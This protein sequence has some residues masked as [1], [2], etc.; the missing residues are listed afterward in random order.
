MQSQKWH[1]DLHSFPR[2]TIQYH[3]N[4][5]LCPDLECWRSW[6]WMLLWRPTRRSRTNTQKRYP[7]HYR[8]LECKS[9]NSRNTWSNRQI[10]PWS[11][12]WG[13]AKTKSFSKRKQWSEQTFSSNNTREDSTHEHQP[14]GQYQNQIDYILC[15]QRWRS[16]IQSTKTRLGA[17]FGSDYELLIPKFRFK[18]KKVGKTTQVWPKSDPLWLYSKGKDSTGKDRLIQGIRS[19]R[20]PEELWMLVCV[21]VQETGIKTTPKKKKCKK[22]K[23]AVWGGLINSCEKKKSKKQRR[24][25]KIFPFE[26]RVP[27]NSKER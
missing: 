5:S 19:D 27:K 10:W 2:Q 14:D 21:T 24:K 13:G 25:G 11:I 18:L 26:Y 9:R 16:S 23:M 4:P 12:D 6:K 8:E 15:S 7:F 3:S 22:S 1:N 20:V 17:D